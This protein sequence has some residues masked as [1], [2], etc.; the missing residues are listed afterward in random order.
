M[1]AVHPPP[2]QPRLQL[3]RR[4]CHAFASHPQEKSMPVCDGCGAQV[5]DA[6]IRARIERLEMAT[7]VRPIHIQVLLLGVAPP[8]RAEDYFYRAAE[9]GTERS[10]GARAFFEALLQCTGENPRR[11]ATE[12]E[13]LAEF[14]RRGLF[15]THV[16][17][18][19]ADTEAEREAALVRCAP[20]L[21]KRIQFS[22][23]PKFVAPI[24]S[25]LQSIIPL[26]AAAGMAERLILDGGEPFDPSEN[27]GADRFANAIKDKLTKAVSNT[28]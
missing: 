3:L 16:V 18:C 20:S 1:R 13:A 5:D 10:A 12:P 25:G 4:A 28:A 17:E 21:L 19:P 8:V 23:K 15:F 22:Y 6:H 26:L 9:K 2:A 11:F 24:F 14:Q 7:R 27:P